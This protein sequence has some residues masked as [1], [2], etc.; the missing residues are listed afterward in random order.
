MR[1]IADAFGISVSQLIHDEE[2]L[3]AMTLLSWRSRSEG[4]DNAR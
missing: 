3:K 1:I 4:L 2:A